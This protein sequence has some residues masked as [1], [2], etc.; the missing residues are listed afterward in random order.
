ME[1]ENREDLSR[2]VRTFYLHVRKDALIGPIFNEVIGSEENWEIHLEKLTDF[3]ET[4]LFTRP[5]Y[6]GNPMRAH[7]TVD[8]HS[9]SQLSE[10]HFERWLELWESTINQLFSGEKAERAIKNAH[11]IAHLLLAK[12]RF[13]R[14]TS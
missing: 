14:T 4:N 8:D 1:I 10:A 11:N 9:D 2:L 7:K 6:K 12:I 5:A 3:W 13:F